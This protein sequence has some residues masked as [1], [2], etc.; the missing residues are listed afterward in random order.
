MTI[1]DSIGSNAFVYENGLMGQIIP[2]TI[3]NHLTRLVVHL[4]N[5]TIDA[6]SFLLVILGIDLGLVTSALRS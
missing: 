1:V 3:L 4:V 6:I 2:R 5:E